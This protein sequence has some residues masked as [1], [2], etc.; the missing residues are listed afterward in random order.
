M[1]AIQQALHRLD[2]SLQRL[3]GTVSTVETNMQGQQRDMFG[4]PPAP[5]S[6]ENRQIDVSVVAQRLDIAIEKVEEILSEA[7]T[8]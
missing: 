2:A 4:G 3:E 7:A 5:P 6:N 8:G 1:S